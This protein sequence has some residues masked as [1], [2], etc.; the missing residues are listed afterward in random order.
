MEQKN[1]KL[2]IIPLISLSIFVILIFGAA[3]AY[4]A[5][6][7]SM[8]ISNYQLSLPQQTSLVCVKTDCSVTLTP[9]QMSNSNTSSSSAKSTNTCAVN[10]TC[11]GTEGAICNYDVYVDEIGSMYIPSAS[12]GTNK[13]FTVNVSSPSGKCTAKN[14]SSAETQVNTLSGKKV[15]SCSLTVPAG[16]S[17]S[18]NVQAEFK[19][20]NLSISQNSHASKSYKYQLSTLSSL[21]SDYQAVEFIQSTGTQWIDT[22]VKANLN[23]KAEMEVALVSKGSTSGNIGIFGTQATSD[24][25]TSVF[26]I[27]TN[28]GQ[29]YIFAQFDSVSRTAVSNLSFVLGTK[30]KFTLSKNGWYYNTTLGAT[31]TNPTSFTT[32]YNIALFRENGSNNYAFSNSKYYYCKIWDNETLVRYFI[33]CKRISDNKAGMYD[34]VNGVFYTDA[35]G[36]NFTAGDNITL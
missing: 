15:S 6:N 24:Q 19:W 32:T 22:G 20:Y 29:S 9:A 7:T 23:T 10:C 2:L 35:A 36:G 31:W 12:L 27:N 3:Y 30:Y 28:S 13:E 8:N 16:G 17:I 4:Y 25:N 18:A 33:P 26:A 11:S 1:T 5:A 14:S 21:P 34:L